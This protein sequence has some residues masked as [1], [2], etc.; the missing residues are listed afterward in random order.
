MLQTSSRPHGIVQTPGRLD[1][2]DPIRVSAGHCR[3][4]VCRHVEMKAE[5]TLVASY[6]FPVSFDTHVSLACLGSQLQ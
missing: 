4:W 5:G 2:D 1:L 3:S 6:T